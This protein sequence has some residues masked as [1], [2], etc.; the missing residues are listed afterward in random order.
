ML[1][2][3]GRCFFNYV[4]TRVDDQER[5]K[6]KMARYIEG[7]NVQYVDCGK[8]DPDFM[9]GGEL[10]V[11]GKIYR[12]SVLED[13]HIRFDVEVP[14]AEDV[15]FNLHFLR[16]GRRFCF[17]P[18]LRG[19]IYYLRGDSVLQ[20]FVGK[21]PEQVVLAG[22]GF[23][24]ILDYGISNGLFMDNIL[25]DLIGYQSAMM[26]ACTNLTMNQRKELKQL[27]L[28]FI[29]RLKMV[30]PSGCYDKKLLRTIKLLPKA[31]IMRPGL[32]NG[33]SALIRLLRIDMNK[34][35]RQINKD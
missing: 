4:T 34:K 9:H 19:Y 13:N 5:L 7:K 25:L 6:I 26:L 10:T 1:R 15:Y 11:T 29:D 8:C 35:I 27:Y 31:V 3:V 33:V 24:H 20:D 32:M 21:T 23:A 16:H 14:I 17:L 22:K 30:S 18:D 28:P 2:R 12:R